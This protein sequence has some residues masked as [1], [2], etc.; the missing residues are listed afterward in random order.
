MNINFKMEK[1]R[2][3]NKDKKM[4]KNVLWV[5]D[6]LLKPIIKHHNCSHMQTLLLRNRR[7]LAQSVRHILVGGLRK[8]NPRGREIA[9]VGGLRSTACEWLREA[10]TA[11]HAI[12]PYVILFF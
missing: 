11:S 9:Q 12:L 8:R 1:E 10:H 7:H 6:L 4:K 2:I 3:K 5:K